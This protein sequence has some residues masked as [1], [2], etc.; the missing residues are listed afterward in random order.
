[1]E[2]HNALVDG[3]QDSD[4]EQLSPDS[5]WSLGRSQEEWEDEGEV[6]HPLKTVGDGLVD[7][8]RECEGDGGGDEWHEEDAEAADLGGGWA[9][10]VQP[11]MKRGGHVYLDL[12]SSVGS[13]VSEGKLQRLVAVRSGIRALYLH[14]R[15][16]RWGD[17][18]PC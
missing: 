3:E 16:S 10:I 12:C 17:L 2:T 14:A 7:L 4:V 11:P 5:S 18:W 8:D 1:M 6:V 9:R 13:D 15:K